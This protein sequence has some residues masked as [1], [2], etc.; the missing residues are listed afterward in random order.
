MIPLSSSAIPVDIPKTIGEI[1]STVLGNPITTLN[2]L[3]STFGTPHLGSLYI[4]DL[5]AISIEE[6]NSSGFFFSRKRKYIV[7]QEMHAKEGTMVKKNRVLLDGQNLEDEDFA[8]EVADT[9]GAFATTNFF[10][11]DNLK[12]R[13]KKRNQMIAQLQ[14]QMRNTKNN[15]RDE[16]NKGLEKDRVVDKQEIQMLKSSLNEMYKNVKAIQGQ[17]IHQEESIK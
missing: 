10:L 15:I 12:A 1:Q 8:T 6:M 17:F 4:R 9:L 2:H 3:Q 11:V 5:T 14:S 7:K 13:L 16:I